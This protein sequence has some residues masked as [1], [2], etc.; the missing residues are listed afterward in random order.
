VRHIFERFYRASDVKNNKTDGSGLGL[1][2]A[3][4]IVD[5]HGGTIEVLNREG[6]GTRF[7][8]RLKAKD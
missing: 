8:V 6:V 4:W 1:S 5:A 7:T 2:I 3:K